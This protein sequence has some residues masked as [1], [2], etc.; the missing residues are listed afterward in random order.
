MKNAV[1]FCALNVFIFLTGD[2]V[3]AENVTWNQGEA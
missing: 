3:R 1:L 2:N